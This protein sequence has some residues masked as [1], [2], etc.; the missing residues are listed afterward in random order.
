MAAGVRR[1]RAP[2]T[3]GSDRRRAGHRAR[4][5]QDHAMGP[6]AVDRVARQRHLFRRGNGTPRATRMPAQRQA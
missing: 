6:R 2:T 4:H 5:A 3:N 1:Q